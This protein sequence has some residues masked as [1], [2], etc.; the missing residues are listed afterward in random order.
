MV[1]TKGLACS[2]QRLIFK[3]ADDL[4]GVLDT[5]V[6]VGVVVHAMAVGRWSAITIVAAILFLVVNG[7]TLVL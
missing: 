5:G 3:G 7:T 1:S 4:D 6:G 2:E